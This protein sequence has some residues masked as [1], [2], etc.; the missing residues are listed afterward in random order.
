MPQATGETRHTPSSSLTAVHTPAASENY[1]PVIQL[2][3]A[4]KAEPVYDFARYEM[5]F[6]ERLKLL[7]MEIFSPEIPFTQTEIPDKCTY[8]D[9]KD[10]CR[11]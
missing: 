8:C 5:E 1:T 11:K 2:G 6:R 9:F 3:E 4:R 10:L 7:L